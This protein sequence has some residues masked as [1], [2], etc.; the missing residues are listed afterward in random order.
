M[1]GRLFNGML[2]PVIPYSIRGA[3]W[4]QGE[5]NAGRHAQ[6]APPVR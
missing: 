1:P 3:I 6:Y 5:S 4:Y 2:A